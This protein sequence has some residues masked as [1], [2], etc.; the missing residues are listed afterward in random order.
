M[1]A[2][3]CVLAFDLSHYDLSPV[4]QLILIRLAD[5]VPDDPQVSSEYLSKICNCSKLTV[6]SSIKML[7]SVGAINI[8]HEK[9]KLNTYSLLFDSSQADYLD[10]SISSED[11]GSSDD[12]ESENALF[13]SLTSQP[14]IAQSVV[15][16]LNPKNIKNRNKRKKKKR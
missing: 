8:K 10:D 6:Y 1:D 11:F 9:G 2:V 16:K 3:E 15:S 5:I 14:E 7:E 12:Y 4:Q 13:E